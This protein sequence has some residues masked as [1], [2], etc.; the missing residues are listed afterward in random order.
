M[1]R[2]TWRA[3]AALCAVALALHLLTGCPDTEQAAQPTAAPDFSLPN[4]DG[5]QVTL[6]EHRGKVVFLDFWATWCPPC[7]AAIPHI[8]ELQ[9]RYRADGFVALGMSMDLDPEEL[10]DFLRRVP[11]N[12]PILQVDDNTRV[13]FGGVASIPQGFLVDRKGKIRK[14]FMGFSQPIAEEMEQLIQQ[15]LSEPP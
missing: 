14:K 2:S 9:N 7:R 13:A 10:T 4:L 8:V 5:E 3:P 12:Y 6:S 11:V 1:K 15:L